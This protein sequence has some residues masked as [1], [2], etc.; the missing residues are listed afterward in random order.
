MKQFSLKWWQTVK[1]H[2]SSMLV[3]R[4]NFALII[5]GPVLVFFFVKI[6]LW[7][8]I[9]QGDM[10]QTIGHYTLKDMLTYHLWT[11]I[12]MLISRAYNSPKLSEDIRLGKVSTYLIYPFSLWEFNVTLFIARLI[13]QIF[14]ALFTLVLLV[15]VFTSYFQ[16]VIWVD[17]LQGLS[18]CIVVGL[19]WFSLQ[20]LVGLMAF[21][22]EETWVIAVIA[23]TVFQ[24]LSGNII[25]LDLFPAWAEQALGYTPFPYVTFIP[26]KLFMGQDIDFITAMLNLVFWIMV[27]NLFIYLVWRRGLKLYT[28]AGM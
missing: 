19:F 28:G 15:T 12:V 27:M 26:V 23:E 22:L 14:I 4:T 1:V 13:V 5:I 6:S 20:Y 24:L 16:E 10:T 3:Y 7:Y 21:W 9:F 18:F 8:S 2:W 25:P 11:M 17:F